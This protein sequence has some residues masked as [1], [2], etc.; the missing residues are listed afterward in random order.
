V[1]VGEHRRDVRWPAEV[2][3]GRQRDPAVRVLHAH[4]LTLE[5]VSYPPA[6]QLAARARESRVRRTLS[7]TPD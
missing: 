4:G 6:D 7:P 5:E 1:V 3:H 2:L